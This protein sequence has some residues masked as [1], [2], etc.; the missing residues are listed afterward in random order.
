MNRVCKGV[1]NT[2]QFDRNI[3][4]SLLQ[5][6][7]SPFF[8]LIAI[9]ISYP[10]TDSSVFLLHIWQY[11]IYIIVEILLFRKKHSQRVIG[12]MTKGVTFPVLTSV[13]IDQQ[14]RTVQRYLPFCKHNLFFYN[15]IQLISSFRSICLND[16]ITLYYYIVD[17]NM[18]FCPIYQNYVTHL[19]TQY[20]SSLPRS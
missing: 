20:L 11:N 2:Y 4:C 17:N 15:K 9:K 1:L 13:D 10:L 3:C 18:L 6:H 5:A 16:I 19:Q 14:I 7:L 12:N 8:L